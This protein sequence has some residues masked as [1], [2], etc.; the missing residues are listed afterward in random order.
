MDV[1]S[2]A[3]ALIIP[4]RRGLPMPL[5]KAKLFLHEAPWWARADPARGCPGGRISPV[6]C[7]P[8]HNTNNSLDPLSVP[9][10]L[11]GRFCAGP[12]GLRGQARGAV[13]TQETW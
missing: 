2:S 9:S 3:T 13:E 4:P 10:A 11:A 8:L 1:H 5:V 7:R 12:E 6:D